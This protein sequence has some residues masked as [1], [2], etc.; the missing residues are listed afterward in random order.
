MKTMSKAGTA[1]IDLEYV[2][3]IV[4][5]ALHAG[6]SD[7]EA[8]YSEGDEFETEV[9]L[10]QV[11]T[12]KE[13]G[14]RALGLRVLIGQRTA[15]TSTSDLSPEGVERLVSGAI[16][17]ARVTSEDPFAGLPERAAFGAV[18]GDLAL[19]HED[20]Y[21][22]PAEGRI[23]YAR[24][25]EAASLAADARITN[26]NGG[27]FQAATGRKV[28]ANSRGFAGEYRTSYCSIVAQPI[29][30]DANGAMQ[31]DYWF[32]HARSLKELETPESV[33]QEAARRALR[34]LGARKVSTQRVPV[35]FAPEIAPSILG[36]ILQAVN[37]DAIYRQASFLVGKLGERVAAANLTIVDDGTMPGRFGTRPFDG[38]GLP[39][40]RTVVLE[41]GVLQSYLLNTYTARKLGLQSTGNAA[42]GLAGTPGIGAG[43]FY[44][45]PGTRT[46]QKILDAIPSGLYV[47]ELIG[48]GGN[49][50]TGDYSCGASGLWIENGALA[51]PVE[52]ITIAGDMKEMLRNITAIGSDLI[53][54][55]SVACPT[56]CIEG[57][58]VA[59]E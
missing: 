43:N 32:S 52:E 9:R 2:T 44:L 55:G 49:T 41:N 30:Q 26:S 6:A 51:Y 40:R 21:S 10:G 33:G 24:R 45:Q 7:A 4:T 5:R 12:L 59:G 8:V 18:S 1:S 48:Q 17:L 15:S 38:E 27:S 46:Q 35:V 23:E 29:A 22:L 11:E 20:V 16:A 57:M 58:T 19:Y 13:S 31:R 53:F 28:L 36:E 3:G 47:T 54:Y 56:L 37:G 42:R 50:V 34:R 39:T 25:A 14:S